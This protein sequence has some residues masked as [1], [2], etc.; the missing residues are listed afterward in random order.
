[1]TRARTDAPGVGRVVAASRALAGLVKLP[2]RTGCTADANQ[3]HAR[4]ARMFQIVRLALDDNGEVDARRPPQQ[5]FELPEDPMAMAE[6]DPSGV[7]G[8]GGCEEEG[9]CWWATDAR[10]RKYRCVVESVATADAA[11]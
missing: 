2:Q 11:A 8:D 4:I 10:G 6:F 3:F 5:L 9:D 7:G 1:M